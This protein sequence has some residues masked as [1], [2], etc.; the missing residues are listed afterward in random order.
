MKTVKI[1][2]HVLTGISFMLPLVVGSGLAIAVGQIMQ[3][4]GA[5][6]KLSN[7]IVQLGVYGM[8]MMVPV[9]SASIAYS[10][11]DKPGIAPGLIL[12]LLANDIKAGFLG[13][14]FFGFFVG[15]VVL[16]LKNH[17]K[18]PKTMDSLVPI[19]IIPLLSILFCGLVGIY[20]IGVPLVA[21]QA[22]LTGFLQNMDQSSKFIT[23]AIMGGMAGFDF[24]GP[25]NK[26]MSLF[27]DGMLIEKIYEPEAIKVMCSM[28]PP[29][30]VA[31]SVLFARKK[32]NRQEIEETKIAFPMGLCMI[33]E[34]VIPIAARDPFRVIFSTTV[35]GM[36]AGGLSMM[37]GVGSTIPSGGVFI[38]PFMIKPFYFTLALVIGSVTTAILL[39]LL[40]PNA[41]EEISEIKE[42]K[43]DLGSIKITKGE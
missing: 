32:W 18:V 25:V 16:Y 42:V 20:V 41:S 37:W 29:L 5:N 17:I 8:G 22:G 40:K 11:A 27:A 33:T 3:R 2:E 38:I 34:G 1:K 14:I 43:L 13:G 9:F 31:L 39:T 19:M 4:M 35:G 21:L 6:E 10:I 26:T 24:G 23:G 7:D 36:I 12:G 28:V 30:G 15:Y